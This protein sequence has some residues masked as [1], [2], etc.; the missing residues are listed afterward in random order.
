MAALDFPAS[1]TVGQIYNG[2]NGVSYTWDGTVWTVPQGGTDLW[3]I[4]GTT[5]TPVDATKTVSVPGDATKASLILS[6]YSTGARVR[7]Q[8]NNN[9]ATIPFLALT[10]NRDAVSGVVDDT[11]KPAWQILLR[12][13][14][15]AMN[16]GRVPAGGALATLLTLD[17]G[18]SLTLP[19]QGMNLSLGGPMVALLNQN[20]SGSFGVMTNNPWAP[21]DAT[22]ASW[23]MFLDV[24]TDSIHVNRRQPNAAAGT[25]PILFS[26]DGNANV[27][28]TG[29]TVGTT[30]N[31]TINGNTATKNTGTTWANP[32]DERMKKNVADYG[33]GLDA[34]TRLRP[35]SFEYNGELGS[36]DDGR[37]CYGFIA[38]EVEPV[39][40]DCVG[41]QEWS[42]TAVEEGEPKPAPITLKTLDQSN[43]ILALVNA[44]RELA[45]RVVA[46]EAA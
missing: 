6:N 14:A 16:I 27:N 9:A 2:T 17:S 29:P 25:A 34:I 5:L 3:T 40:P 30:G 26:L 13:D 33:T 15:D 18:G 8:A 35:V 43:I 39:M 20:T 37:T 32:S 42:P 44:V 4:S 1:P 22:K 46:L 11:T 24:S 38:Q 41:T 45:T 21:Q 19:G 12:P 10:A 36:V 28:I 7:V 23:A 31:L